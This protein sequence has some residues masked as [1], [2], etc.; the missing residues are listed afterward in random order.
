[1]LSDTAVFSYKVDNIYTPE[2]NSGIKWND[3]TLNIDWKIAID[4]IVLSEKDQKLQSLKDL[5]TPF[6]Y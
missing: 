5:K 1:M 6:I 4:K 3:E 2:C